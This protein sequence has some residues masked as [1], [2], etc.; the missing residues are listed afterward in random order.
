MPTA[1]TNMALAVILAAVTTGSAATAQDDGAVGALVECVLSDGATPC[2]DDV[3]DEQIDEAI[4]ILSERTGGPPGQIR[5]QVQDVLTARETPQSGAEAPEVAAEPAPQQETGQEASPAP[6]AEE[7]EPAPEAEQA[8]PAPEA[9]Q[10]AP[11]AQAE[12][13]APSAEP[14]QAAPAEAEQTPPAEAEQAAPA[15]PEQ[16]PPAEA[17][18]PAP[19][20]AEAPVEAEA[21]E[22]AEAAAEPEAPVGDE[23]VATEE[24][25]EEP[26]A[27]QSPATEPQPAPRATA[28]QD[29]DED[30]TE[31]AV[32]APA[33]DAEPEAPAAAQ[34]TVE[35]PGPDATPEEIAAALSDMPDGPERN[36]LL[37]RLQEALAED[38]AATG[39]ATEAE[40]PEAEEL[41]RRQEMADE[42]EE[43]ALSSAALAAVDDSEAAPEAASVVETET[44]VVTEETARSSAEDA[45][46]A[47]TEAGTASDDDDDRETLRNILGGA[48]AGF[49]IGQLLDSGDEVV[50][51]T[52]D[53]VIVNR[54]GEYV[55]LS[56]EN[57][58]LRRP[59]TRVESETYADGSS[60]TVFLRDDG[61]EVITVR[62]PDGRILYRSRIE[63]DGRRVVLIDERVDTAPVRLDDLPRPERSPVIEYERDVSP[64]RLARA[65]RE[66]DTAEQ[67]DRA[68][69]LRQVRT[70]R[71]LRELMP[72]IDLE[73]IT[74][75]TGS[76]AIQPSQAQELS[77][78]GTAMARLIEE[79]P[80]EIFLIEG[81][82]DTVGSEI[83]NLALSD[84]R[85][86]SVA[87]A[88]TEYFGIPP[89]NMVTQGYGERYLK[90][91]IE[92]DV[93]ENRRAA[94]RRI[95][96]LI[97]TA[98]R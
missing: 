64:D 72:R 95:T 26:Q 43:A 46:A 96:P 63:P 34:A 35:M 30:S 32:E 6:Q 20:A 8:A 41:Q 73:A 50:A 51:Q 56:D 59:G 48:A 84:R 98:E 58:L 81:H 93:R 70:I 90:Y 83:M 9:E 87:L 22:A 27:D 75:P 44:E 33:A 78:L 1:K 29:A 62:A 36:E 18:P 85:A 38:A 54:D 66:V 13:P 14:E 23:A 37:A 82:T 94:V 57:T 86:E 28:A 74:F 68:Y 55:V 21:P 25:P 92:G 7:P 89:E 45:P 49:I 67:L 88:L 39:P 16:T 52:G 17:A 24:A 11:P 65:L 77:A 4:S 71:E 80:D 40:A 61:S 10:A 91:P 3:T 97:R 42:A 2:P 76:A 31:E 79:N 5:Q 60:R 53:R 69:S 47:R 15:E 19:E 12:A